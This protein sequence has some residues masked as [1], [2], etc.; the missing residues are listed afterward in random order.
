MRSLAKSSFFLFL[1]AAL[2]ASSSAR[3]IPDDEAISLDLVKAPL[4]QILE[5][6]AKIS[7]SELDAEPGL[8]GFVTMKTTAP[9]TELF[10]QV[11]RDHG[12]YCEILAGEPRQL[13]V[14]RAESAAGGSTL[15]GRIAMPAGYKQAV[16]LSLKSAD[17]GKTL[18][19]FAAI[20]GYSIDLPDGLVGTLTLNVQGFP[21]PVLVSEISR[22]NG[23]RAVWGEKSIDLVELTDDEKKELQLINMSL[24]NARAS[25][26]VS[27]VGQIPY[28][29]GF[30]EVEVE[31]D[32]TLAERTVTVELHQVN[33]MQTLDILCGQLGC[34]WGLR[35][36]DPVVLWIERSTDTAVAAAAEVSAPADRIPA[37]QH[38]GAEP[39]ELGFRFVPL[40]SPAVEGNVRFGW[41]S[42]VQ[43]LAPTEGLQAVLSWVPFDSRLSVVLVMVRRCAGEGSSVRLFDPIVLPLEEERRFEADGATLELRGDR[44][45]DG[46][47]P[48]TAVS[49]C[50]PERQ[51]PIDVLVRRVEAKSKVKLPARGFVLESYVLVTPIDARHPAAAVIDLGPD[52]KGRQLL[53]IVRPDSERTGVEVERFA[54]GPDEERTIVLGAEGL[55]FEMVVGFRKPKDG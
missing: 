17:L 19:S 38:A 32:E 48:K 5:S 44:R 12:L 9:W 28:F 55:E 7:G 20:S 42:P 8:E 31:F 15:P 10:D 23:Y 3:Q 52:A 29:F 6:F 30:E 35:Y 37:I 54:L 21:W 4:G 27:S 24:K 25:E 45:F 2:A 14:R 11:C 34:D 16:N 1:A 36:G 46:Y 47:H 50:G 53:A 22:L 40:A 39:R 26:L 18:E 41:A 13:R 33:Y 49:G 51:V 43:V